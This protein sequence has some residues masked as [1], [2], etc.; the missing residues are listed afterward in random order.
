MLQK[1]RG[2][3]VSMLFFTSFT[4]YPVVIVVH[5][6]FGATLDW[7]KPGGDFF[8]PLELEAERLGHLVVPFCWSG[9]PTQSQINAAASVLAKLIMSYPAGAPIIL[10]GHSHGGNVINRA[11][12]LLY[13][14]LLEIL[15]QATSKPLAEMLASAHAQL[16]ANPIS[17]QKPI[18]IP[19]PQLEFNELDVCPTF[20][21]N[22]GYL[23][24]KIYLLGTPICTERYYPEMKIVGALVNLF[25]EGDLIQPVLGMYRRRLPSQP[26]VANVSVIFKS[27]QKNSMLKPGHSALHD[28]VVGQWL[29]HIPD[30]LMQKGIGN[31][32]RFSY[33]TN[34]QITF[35][36]LSHPLFNCL[37]LLEE[38]NSVNP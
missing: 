18:S 32:Q 7:W 1:Y 5:G 27:Y 36:A 11:S 9:E 17:H 33:S 23:I 25:S 21:R 16:L 38:S 12:Q 31:F 6:S 8:T 34:S 4:L 2:L 29:L 14:P 35:D 15:A 28:P 24:D 26:R 37:S 13:N 22:K 19:I 3:L 30:E 20:R 10:V